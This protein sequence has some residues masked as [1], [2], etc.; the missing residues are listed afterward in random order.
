MMNDSMK[1]QSME[2]SE[3]EVRSRQEEAQG[4]AVRT[5]EETRSR[6]MTEGAAAAGSKGDEMQ[7]RQ[8]ERKEIQDQYRTAVK[9]GEAEKTKGKKPWWKFWGSDEETE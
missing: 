5:E 9:E 1:Q 7:A 2:R 4:Q 6:A 3:K 8:Q